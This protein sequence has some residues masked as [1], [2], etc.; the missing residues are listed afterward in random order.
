MLSLICRSALVAALS[1]AFS[2]HLS[3]AAVFVAG[4]LADASDPTPGDGVCDVDPVTAGEQCTLR[5]AIQT[6]NALPGM[7]SV[8]LVAGTYEL[9]LRGPGEDLAATD[10]LDVLEAVEVLGQGAGITIVDAKKLKHRIF[11]VAG[12]GLDL[13]GVTLQRG[14][15]PKQ[16]TDL[17]GGCIRSSGNLA[18]LNSAI[19]LCKARGGGGGIAIEGGSAFLQDTTISGNRAKV[20][21]G[22][23]I[24]GADGLLDRVT[25][26]GNKAKSEGGGIGVSTATLSVGNSTISGNKAREG[27][28]LLNEAGGSLEIRSSTIAFNK[29]KTG[30]RSP[31][32][33][34]DSER[35]RCSR[36]RSCTRRRAC[37]A[38]AASSPRAATWRAARAAGWRWRRTRAASI[39][40]STS[41]RTTAER[42]SPTRSSPAAR[43]STSAS[44]PTARPPTS[45]ARGASTSPA[46]A[47]RSATPA[48][49]RRRPERRRRS[50]L[51]GCARAGPPPRGRL[52]RPAPR[53]LRV[54][55]APAPRRCSSPTAASTSRAPIDGFAP[56]LADAGW[57]VVSFD[58]RGHG[59]SDHAALY[60]WDADAR[61]ALAVLDSHDAR[62]PCPSSA[63]RRAARS[64]PTSRR[65]ART[66]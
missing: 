9:S 23:E 31:I 45:A 15:V 20:G 54:G 25:L 4:E 7:D 59:D 61:D 55:R 43:R 37:P 53:R 2:P 22:L 39:R 49:S 12:G 34:R 48:P 24:G 13:V 11:D 28:G 62:S 47:P 36:T 65:P 44:T 1:V 64:S 5:A 33:T 17:G 50:G 38:R 58:Q 3:S 35:R 60:N 52:P 40:S 46:S 51:P 14:S 57:R 26:S 42:R 8:Q 27:G 30:P 21:G 16:E 6:A 66:A 10:D 41:S 29:A 19:T 63:T 32:G 56:L 18:V